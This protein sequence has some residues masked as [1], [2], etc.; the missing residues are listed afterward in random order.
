ML[1]ASA[2]FPKTKKSSATEVA[3]NTEKIKEINHRFH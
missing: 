2:F 3:E 1:D